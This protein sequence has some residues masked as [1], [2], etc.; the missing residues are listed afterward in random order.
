MCPCV[1]MSVRQ[2][3]VSIFDGAFFVFLQVRPF[4]PLFSAMSVGCLLNYCPLFLDF[5]HLF[6]KLL[7]PVSESAVTCF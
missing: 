3:C 5:C 7:V 1:Y 4:V 6:L 2:H